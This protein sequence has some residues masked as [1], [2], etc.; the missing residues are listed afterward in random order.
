[1]YQTSFFSKEASEMQKKILHPRWLVA[2]LTY[3]CPLSCFYCSNPL[4]MSSKNELSTRTWI[5]ALCQGRELGCVQLGLTGGEPLMRPDLASIV[6]SARDMGYYTNLITSAVGL[7]AKKV[8]ELRTAGLDSVQIS[9]QADQRALNE[10]IGGKDTYVHKVEMMR[11]VKRAGLPLTL[12]VVIHRLNIDR[13]AEICALCDSMDPDYVEIASTQYHGWASVNRNVLLPTPDQVRTA[14]RTIEEYQSKT[15]SG[16]FYVL[17]DLI[18]RR[19]KCCHQ[20]WGTTYICINPQGEVTPCLSAHTLPSLRGKIQ[21][22]ATSSLSDIWNGEVF[23]KYRGDPL[24]WMSENEA[25]ARSHAR[26]LDDLG[27]CRCQAYHL[28]GDE[29]AMDP[30]DDTSV[31]HDAFVDRLRRDWEAPTD[32][33]LLRPRKLHNAD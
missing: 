22:V 27:G 15:N 5:S 8:D 10:F 25:Y 33:A 14:Q 9:F 24:G 20:G 23:S 11:E 1:M 28:T 4:V 17:P 13:I 12:N 6:K 31:H 19:A 32:L 29:C 26:R 30:A 2:E 18:E 3:R 21:N 16:V 7:N